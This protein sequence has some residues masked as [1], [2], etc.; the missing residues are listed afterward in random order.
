MSDKMN[1]KDRVLM[2]K[3][4]EFICRHINNEEIFEGWLMNGVADGDISYGDLELKD[5]KDSKWQTVKY[6][7]NDPAIDYAEDDASFSELM[8]CF[9]RMMSSARKDGGLY[10]DTVV[11]KD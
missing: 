2:V 10:C 3:A 4:M 7:W 9:L 8:G 5:K 1:L 6:W 11:S